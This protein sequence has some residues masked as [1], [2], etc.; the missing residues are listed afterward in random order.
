MKW[1]RRRY[2]MVDEEA[3]VVLAIATFVRTPNEPRRRN[4]FMEFFYIDHAR[5][6]DVYAALIYP[7]PSAPVPN[8]PPYDGNF[9]LPADFGATK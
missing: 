6:R 5:I 1:L 4:H 7:P 3:Q 9:P 2:P 8:W